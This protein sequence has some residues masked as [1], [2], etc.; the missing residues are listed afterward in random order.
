METRL[1]WSRRSR[2][3]Q[4]PPAGGPAKSPCSALSS[5]TPQGTRG[6]TKQPSA[7]PPPCRLCQGRKR[8]DF[9]GSSADVSAGAYPG[10]GRPVGSFRTL[11]RCLPW[12]CSREGPP[13]RLLCRDG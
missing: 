13:P 5:L 8:R 7:P 3:V 4:E 12:R 11:G 2:S 10:L 6:R 1:A 9:G